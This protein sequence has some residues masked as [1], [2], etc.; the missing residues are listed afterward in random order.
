MHQIPKEIPSDDAAIIEP[1][2]CAIHTVNRAEVQLDDVLVIAGAGP[3]GLMM[4]QVAKLKTPKCLIV[5]DPVSER[6]ALAKKYGAD[7]VI[8]PITE[9]VNSIVRSLTQGYGCDVYIEA[10][11]SPSG[12]E[13]GLEIIRKLGRFVEFSVFGKSTTVDL[14][15]IHI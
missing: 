6:R 3:I 2:A 5:V 15:L 4:V 12:V 8:D 7:V 9:N 1:L 13:Q 14:S 11:G 10:T